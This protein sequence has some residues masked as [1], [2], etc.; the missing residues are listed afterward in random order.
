MQQSRDVQS[1]SLCAVTPALW[2]S[3]LLLEPDA[4]A[5][6]SA[7][8]GSRLAGYSTGFASQYIS[9]LVLQQLFTGTSCGAWGPA[10]AVPSPAAGG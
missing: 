5:W 8:E 7:P 3:D 2:P 9:W 1:R 4:A 10:A 6:V